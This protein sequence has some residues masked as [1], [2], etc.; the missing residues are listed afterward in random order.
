[1]C[2][3]AIIYARVERVV[4][5]APDPKAGACGSVFDQ[6]PADGRFTYRTA[7]TGGVLADVGGETL[8]AFFRARRSA[9][10]MDKARAR[11]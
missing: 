6:L 2:A 11:T 1:M 8:R 3:E 10:A 5:G 7:C 9:T 4:Y